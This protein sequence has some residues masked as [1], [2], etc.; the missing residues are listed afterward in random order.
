[1][2]VDWKV[3]ATEGIECQHIHYHQLQSNDDLNEL[4]TKYKKSH[5]VAMI[6]V[7]T[8]DNYELPQEMCRGVTRVKKP[9]LPAIVISL[10]DGKK[11]KEY[12]ARHDPG[13]LHARFE[14]KK[15]S[16]I[17]PSSV[18]ADNAPSPSQPPKIKSMYNCVYQ[19]TV[20]KQCICMVG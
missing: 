7:N 13:E 4:A 2:R 17:E 11:V 19:K 18:S 15:Q 3:L 10:E 6:L 14:S 8:N 12:L 16:H 20:V 1:M 9:I 5:A